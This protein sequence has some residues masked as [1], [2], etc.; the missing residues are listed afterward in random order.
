MKYINIAVADRR[1][2]TLGIPEIVCGNSDYKIRFSFD[3]E[4]DAHPVKTARFLFRNNDGKQCIDRVF[5]GDTVD[6]PVLTNTSEVFVGVFASDLHTTSPA[7]IPATLSIRCGT[8]APIDP[9]PSVYDQIIELINQGGGG[10]G[11]DGVS[12]TVEVTETERGHLVKITDVEGEHIFEVAD[13]VDGKDG[14]DGKDGKDGADGA[15]GYTP[16]KGVD[17]FDGVNGVDGKDGADGQDYVLTE[18]DKTEI[19]EQAAALIDTALAAAIGS[20]A[21]V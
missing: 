8:A 16:Q 1:A 18:A 11:R 13:G 19:A 5:D 2:T 4:W 9:E 6:L 3:E 12:P 7:R 14:A 17:Y 20:G 10:G 21:I 15:D